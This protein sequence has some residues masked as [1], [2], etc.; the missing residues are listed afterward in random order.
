MWNKRGWVFHHPFLSPTLQVRIKKHFF[1]FPW[2]ERASPY[3]IPNTIFEKSFQA[4]K[5]DRT[6]FFLFIYYY[7]FINFV[8][9]RC[10]T[11]RISRVQRAY[12]LTMSRVHYRP[13]KCLWLKKIELKYYLSSVPVNS[14]SAFHVF[15][16][17]SSYQIFPSLSHLRPIC[18]TTW[19][20]THLAFNL[21]GREVKLP[22]EFLI[23]LN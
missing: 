18:W 1:F 6:Q 8:F 10:R 20:R 19:R 4:T 12:V 15:Y 17:F 5:S 14:Q 2:M 21:I 13:P 9:V 23:Q 22:I 11:G 7:C 16:A 3:P